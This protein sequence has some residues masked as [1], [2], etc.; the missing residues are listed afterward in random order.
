MLTK[1][2]TH[3]CV[4]Q[5]CCKMR[6]KNV[7]LMGIVGLQMTSSKISLSI[8][9]KF[10]IW[11]VRPYNVLLYQISSHLDQ[12]RQSYISKKL[13][14]FFVTLYGKIGWWAFFS[15]PTWLLQYK[16]METVETLKIL[17]CHIY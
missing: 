9:C 2:V 13:E 15:P 12:G 6:L 5:K 1:R 8:C 17:N 16:C 7:K 11:P 3:I 14:N 4:T 10:F